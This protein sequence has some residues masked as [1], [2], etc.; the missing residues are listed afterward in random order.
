M[1]KRDLLLEAYHKL[2]DCQEVIL[3]AGQQNTDRE[4]WADLCEL[5]KTIRKE[6]DVQ[7]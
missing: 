6:V 4:W 5:I 1:E 7:I 2:L 3:D